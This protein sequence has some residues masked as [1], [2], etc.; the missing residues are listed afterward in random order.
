[1]IDIFEVQS[2]LGA[3][4]ALQLKGLF[5]RFDLCGKVNLY[6]KDGGAKCLNKHYFMCFI[7]V[8]KVVYC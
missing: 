8:G 3:T 1:M 7:I 2:T 6:V 4:L 5:V